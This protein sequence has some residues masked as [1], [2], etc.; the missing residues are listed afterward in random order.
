MTVGNCKPRGT[1]SCR[2][3]RWNLALS[4]AVELPE[5]SRAKPARVSVPIV[6]CSSPLSVPPFL[7][8]PHSLGSSHFLFFFLDYTFNPGFVVPAAVASV[9]SAAVFISFGTATRRFKRCQ[10]RRSP[11]TRLSY[12]PR[13][14]TS[15]ARRRDS[16]Y[17]GGSRRRLS[18][19]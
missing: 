12:R 18:R 7:S 19:S 17:Q 1:F 15:S 2:V 11:Q 13:F 4:T 3:V 6:L 9:A 5:I 8:P 14:R 10:W 16:R